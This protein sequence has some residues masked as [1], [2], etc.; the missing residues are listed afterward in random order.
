MAMA[1][2]MVMAIAMAMAM[3]MSAHHI[4][5]YFELREADM[6]VEANGLEQ[7]IEVVEMHC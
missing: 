3:A 6:E 1:M 2:V 7:E 5:D 4:C